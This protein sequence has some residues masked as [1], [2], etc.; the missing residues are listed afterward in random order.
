MLCLLLVN[1]TDW[2]GI[3]LVV[4]ITKG[5]WC[6]TKPSHEYTCIVIN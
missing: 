1:M 2:Y 6:L 3:K 5:G 4:Y